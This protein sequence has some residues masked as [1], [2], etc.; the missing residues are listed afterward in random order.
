MPEGPTDCFQLP[1]SPTLVSKIHIFHT[2]SDAHIRLLDMMRYD[3]EI[4]IYIYIYLYISPH[5]KVSLSYNAVWSSPV[6]HSS[7]FLKF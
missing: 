7:P 4:Y 5:L 6:A 3:K 1:L 2:K